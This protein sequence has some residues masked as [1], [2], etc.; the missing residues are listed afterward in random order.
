MRRLGFYFLCKVFSCFI[1]IVLASCPRLD[2]G[3][4]IYH[5]VYGDICFRSVFSV[6]FVNLSS[7]K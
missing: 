6:I 3:H 4:V 5:S 7:L 2:I 1:V